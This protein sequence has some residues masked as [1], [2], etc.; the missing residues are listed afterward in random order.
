[1]L[2]AWQAWMYKL[3]LFYNAKGER[4]KELVKVVAMAVKIEMFPELE[5]I[6]PKG[7][8]VID[9]GMVSAL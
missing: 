2:V 5:M 1:M 8:Y 6:P 7:L 3:P 9:T 4:S